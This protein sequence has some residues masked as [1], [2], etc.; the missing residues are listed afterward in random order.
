MF[1]KSSRRQTPSWKSSHCARGGAIGIAVAMLLSLMGSTCGTTNV[2]GGGGSTTILGPNGSNGA[3][4]SGGSNSTSLQANDHV[5][6]DLG[7]A[8][9][10]IEYADFQ[11][12]FCG[13]F[14]RESFPTIKANYIDT[15]KVRWVFRHFPLTTIHDR[16]QAAAEASECAADQVDFFDYHD[17]TFNTVDGTN[18]TILTDSQLLQNA[19]ALGASAG[20]FNSCTTG[21]AKAARVQQDVNSATSLGL[22]STPTFFI[23]SQKVSGFQ[24][25]AQFSAILD[26]QL[27]G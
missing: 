18:T 8:L 10:V 23:G 5:L 19:T 17:L 15:G 25:A 3:G 16:A 27:G 6:G 22:N 7:A 1:S 26:Q 14:A 24:T 13:R 20:T 4:G 21:H 9:T 2:A 12:P 11:C